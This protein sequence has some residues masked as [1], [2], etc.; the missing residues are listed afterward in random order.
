MQGPGFAKPDRYQSARILIE[1]ENVVRL[2]VGCLGL[3]SVLSSQAIAAPA[4]CKSLFE[5]TSE[6]QMPSRFEGADLDQIFATMIRDFAHVTSVTKKYGRRL[7]EPGHFSVHEKQAAVRMLARLLESRDYG[8]VFQTV[9]MP[10]GARSLGPKDT[11]NMIVSH[12]GEPVHVR[13]ETA[14]GRKLLMDMV[15]SFVTGKTEV[16]VS[17]KNFG[18]KLTKAE[19]KEVIVDESSR[20]D[21]EQTLQHEFHDL[22]YRLLNYFTVVESLRTDRK[23]EADRALIFLENDG[24]T[25]VIP[26]KFTTN[27]PGRV[28][29]LEAISVS[30]KFG[31][32]MS[33]FIMRLEEAGYSA[34]AVGILPEGMQIPDGMEIVRGGQGEIS[35]SIEANDKEEEATPGNKRGW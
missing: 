11:P 3:I 16:V 2:I 8:F 17:P 29:Q 12:G 26:Y 22:R 31:D 25:D 32:R 4:T 28:S 1:G 24:G 23:L 14:E 13:G 18:L 33:D 27:Y 35:R 30:G 20:R 19:Q 9:A 5:P 10:K 21:V 15:Y 34:R 7:R 6:F